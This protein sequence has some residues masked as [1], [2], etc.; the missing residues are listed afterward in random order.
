MSPLMGMIW[1]GTTYDHANKNLGEQF[2]DHKDLG[3]N[4]LI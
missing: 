4:L 3:G 1:W 2:L